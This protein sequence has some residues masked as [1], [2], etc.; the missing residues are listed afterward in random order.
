MKYIVSLL[1]LGSTMFASTI[2][3]KSVG[4]EVQENVERAY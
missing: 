3:T 4:C 2:N 1:L